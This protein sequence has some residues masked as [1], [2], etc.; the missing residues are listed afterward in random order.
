MF[1]TFLQKIGGGIRIC[2]LPS[3]FGA[4]A[5]AQQNPH[6]GQKG[7]IPRRSNRH[8]SREWHGGRRR[9]GTG[10]GGRARVNLFRCDAIE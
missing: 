4:T 10:V 7:P 5:P 2:I 3:P 8:G 9:D 1:E 6:G